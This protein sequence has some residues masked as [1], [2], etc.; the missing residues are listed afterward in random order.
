MNARKLQRLAFVVVD[1]EGT[2]LFMKMRW[3]ARCFTLTSLLACLFSLGLVMSLI[4]GLNERALF[5]LEGVGLILTWHIAVFSMTAMVLRAGWYGAVRWQR[6][7][8]LRRLRKQRTKASFV[9]TASR[10]D[11]RKLRWALSSRSSGPDSQGNIA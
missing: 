11:T 1:P 9:D 8:W 6:Q 10:M 5:V 2:H 4:W 7:Y 3:W